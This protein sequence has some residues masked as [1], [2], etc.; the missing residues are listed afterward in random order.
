MAL[1]QRLRNLS[2]TPAVVSPPPHLDHNPHSIHTFPF[3]HPRTWYSNQT[4]PLSTAPDY[5]LVERSMAHNKGKYLHNGLHRNEPLTRPSV[6]FT[7]IN[8]WPLIW[9]ALTR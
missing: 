4:A 8:P 7:Y 1:H 5:P 2:K 9:D 6:V 3:P